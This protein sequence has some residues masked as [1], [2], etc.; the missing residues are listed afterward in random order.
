MFNFHKDIDIMLC[1]WSQ[2]LIFTNKKTSCHLT[3][4]PSWSSCSGRRSGVVNWRR[5]K[6]WFPPLIMDYLGVMWIFW[7]YLDILSVLEY[8]GCTWIF[9]VYLG[10][11]SILGYFGHTWIFWVWC[12]YFGYT[13]ENK[14]RQPVQVGQ[15][16]GIGAFPEQSEIKQSILLVGNLLMNIYFN[17]LLVLTAWI[18]TTMDS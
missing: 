15:G 7:A 16:Q 12:G 17:F 13:W 2:R 5:T 6:W 11:C 8:F 9:W 3:S 18:L 14:R 4:P 1:W 10:I